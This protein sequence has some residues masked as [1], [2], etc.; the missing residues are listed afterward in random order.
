MYMYI[1]H[2]IQYVAIVV[3]LIILFLDRKGMTKYIP[4]AMFA[5]L[6][7]NLWCYIANYFHLWSYQHKLFPIVKDISVTVNMIVVPIV[8][9]I[10]IKHIPKT[11][12]GKFIWT[13]IWTTGLTLDEFLIERYTQVLT[14]HNGYDWYYSYILWFISWFLWAEYH[15]W[16]MKSIMK[17]N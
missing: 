6:Y 13:F 4:V 5:S 8:V 17:T 10:W 15:K 7:S 2:L 12:K 3:S 1:A 9:M 16:Q 14:Y 11:L